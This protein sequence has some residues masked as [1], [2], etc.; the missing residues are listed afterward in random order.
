MK[1]YHRPLIAGLIAVT[2]LASGMDGGAVGAQGPSPVKPFSPVRFEGAA[3][4]QTD[5]GVVQLPAIVGLDP[6]S[7]MD[8]LVRLEAPSL[9]Q[10]LDSVQ[11][12]RA[13]Q[14]AGA[15]PLSIDAI[16]SIH[17]SMIRRQSR[18]VEAVEAAGGTVIGRLQTTS[19]ALHV[20]IPYGKLGAL[21]AVPGVRSMGRMPTF[22]L[23]LKGGH[24]AH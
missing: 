21:A 13:A 17:D 22:E 10:V 14:P 23:Q 4:G 5:G 7:S 24:A 6:G 9:Y 8:L 3:L 12:N 1:S 16:S 18:V 15:Q 19:N 20:R 2:V 11:A